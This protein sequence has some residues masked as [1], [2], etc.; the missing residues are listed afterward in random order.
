MR[1]YPRDCMRMREYARLRILDTPSS[2]CKRVRLAAYA[3]MLTHSRYW[4]LPF[5]WSRFDALRDIIVVLIDFRYYLN[6]DNVFNS[7]TEKNVRCC[8]SPYVRWPLGCIQKKAGNWWRFGSVSQHDLA[9]KNELSS[10]LV[11]VVTKSMF[12]K[13]TFTTSV[14][15]RC[16]SVVSAGKLTANTILLR[17]PILKSQRV[18]PFFCFNFS[19]YY[20]RL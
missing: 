17:P 8:A 19:I 15:I 12:L 5:A 9:K 14:D 1:E 7:L 13:T 20:L 2:F 3:R 4:A 11:L 10:G 18:L 6:K 16:Q